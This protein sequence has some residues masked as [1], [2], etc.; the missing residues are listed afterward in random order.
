MR[1]YT[2]KYRHVGPAPFFVTGISRAEI[3]AATEAEAEAELFRRV[4]V[5]PS[6]VLESYYN[7]EPA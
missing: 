2:F 7:E 5:R 6:D 1:V 3:R 4:G